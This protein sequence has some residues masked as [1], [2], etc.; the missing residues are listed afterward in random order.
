[1]SSNLHCYLTPGTP[2]QTGPT[3]VSALRGVGLKPAPIDCL[4]PPGLARRAR[5]GLQRPREDRP[6]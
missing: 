1:L 6:S 2:T 5:A 3:M 4:H